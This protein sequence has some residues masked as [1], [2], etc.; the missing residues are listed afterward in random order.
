MS[1]IIPKNDRNVEGPSI[2]LVVM[3]APSSAH[4][5]TNVFTLHW[6]MQPSSIDEWSMDVA[7]L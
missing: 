2:L 7:G 1:K 6:H 3:G 5:D 4:K